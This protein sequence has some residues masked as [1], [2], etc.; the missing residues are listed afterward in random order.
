MS[1]AAS[2]RTACGAWTTTCHQSTVS[3]R[4][5][6]RSARTG[7]ERRIAVLGNARLLSGWFRVDEGVKPSE[8]AKVGTTRRRSIATCGQCFSQAM[9]SLSRSDF[10]FSVYVLVETVKLVTGLLPLATSSLAPFLP[11]PCL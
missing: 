10:L 1:V 7:V 11:T 5:Q 2:I 8:L 6:T 9:P 3:S 4:L